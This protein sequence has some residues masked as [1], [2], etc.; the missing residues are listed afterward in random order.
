M[1]KKLTGLLTNP[2]IL[3]YLPIII[4][5]ILM[6]GQPPNT[7]NYISDLDNIADIIKVPAVNKVY[8]LVSSEFLDGLKIEVFVTDILGTYL[9]CTTSKRQW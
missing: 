1:N 4:A 2:V 9:E 7:G 6:N 5:T 3:K 8:R